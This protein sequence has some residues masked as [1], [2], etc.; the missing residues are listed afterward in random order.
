MAAIVIIIEKQC[1]SK[2]RK[3]KTDVTDAIRLLLLWDI[4]LTQG[5]VSTVF[6]A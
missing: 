3:W 1:F 6:E 2:I 4:S 5:T